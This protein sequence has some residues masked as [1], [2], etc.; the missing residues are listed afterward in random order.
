MGDLALYY[1]KKG[2]QAQ[3]LNFIQHARSINREDVDLIYTEAVVVAL[4]NHPDN[5]LKFLR[6]AFER[7]YAVRE[8]RSDPELDTLQSRPGFEKLFAEFNK[9]K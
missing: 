9:P 8:A 2:M 1:A 6:E 5:A 7:G 4:A 3:A